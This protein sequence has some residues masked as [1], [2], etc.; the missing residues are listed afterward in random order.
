[1]R[2]ERKEELKEKLKVPL[3]GKPHIKVFK[4]RCSRKEHRVAVT[5]VGDVIFLDHG[6]ANMKAV[7]T[8]GMM[9]KCLDKGCYYLANLILHATDSYKWFKHGSRRSSRQREA[10]DAGVPDEM[11]PLIQA[12]L[13]RRGENRKKAYERQKM[14]YP[15]SFKEDPWG[16]VSSFIALRSLLVR[17]KML[18]VAERLNEA[19]VKVAPEYDPHRLALY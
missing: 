11:H 10:F 5:S 13:H 17:Q 9:K 7:Y 14:D 12:M 8:E 1:M 6:G 2:R 15:K 19:G 3:K 16:R 18:R 4:I